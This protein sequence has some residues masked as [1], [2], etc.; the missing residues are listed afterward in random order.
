MENKYLECMAECKR[1]VDE[2]KSRKKDHI[3]DSLE[4]LK[5]SK[6]FIIDDVDGLIDFGKVNRADNLMLPF[7]SVAIETQGLRKDPEK[8]WIGDT[9]TIVK[10]VSEKEITLAVYSRI[11][12]DKQWQRLMSEIV[13]KLNNR[14]LFDISCR[15]VGPKMKRKDKTTT[16]Q[17]IKNYAGSLT[18]VVFGLISFLQK[19]P[20]EIIANKQKRDRS[21][22]TAKLPASADAYMTVVLDPTKRTKG[23]SKGGSHASPRAHE[24]RGFW[25]TSKNGVKHW[26]A[27]TIVNPSAGAMVIKDYVISTSTA[28]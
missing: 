11:N 13:V 4:I 24:R 12:P 7:K 1:C 16:Q 19:E 20:N 9:V 6:R 21:L 15:L 28:A 26:V 2:R 27:P 18:A 3:T 10:Q 22:S 8:N 17:T 25:R 23:K 5:G 14:G